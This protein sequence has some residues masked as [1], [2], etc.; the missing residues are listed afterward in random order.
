MILA[1]SS[2]VPSLF[3]SL[4]MQAK[5]GTGNLDV[6]NPRATGRAP[7]AYSKALSSLPTIFHIRF[8]QSS[9]VRPYPT[10]LQNWTLAFDSSTVRV[11]STGKGMPIHISSRDR[12][13]WVSRFCA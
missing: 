11:F 9:V 4:G 12:S 5:G 1:F 13:T 2:T 6:V 8:P 7:I 3:G 10:S